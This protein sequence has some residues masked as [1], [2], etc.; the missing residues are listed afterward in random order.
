MRCGACPSAA[1]PSSGTPIRMLER[2]DRR[3]RSSTT[4]LDERVAPRVAADVVRPAARDRLVRGLGDVRLAVDRQLVDLR[5]GQ[6]EQ[7]GQQRDGGDHRDGD[8]ERRRRQPIAVIGREAGE[9]QA[10]DGDDDGGAGEQHGLTGGG[11]GGAGRVL[12]AHA[13][14][15]V[16]AVSGDDEQRVVDADAEADHHAEDQRDLGHV[17]ERRQDADAGDADEDAD[18]RGDDREAHRDHRAEGDEQH[19]DGDAEADQLAASIFLATSAIVPVSSTCTPA[20]RAGLEC[21]VDRVEVR[22]LDLVDEV[23]HV[24]ERGLAVGA[25]HGVRPT[26][27]RRRRRRRAAS[28]PSRRPRRC[29]PSSRR[30]SSVWSTMRPCTPPWPGT[31]LQDVGAGCDST[32]G[33]VNSVVRSRRRGR[34][35]SGEHGDGDEEPGTYDPP[36]VAGAPMTESVEER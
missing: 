3:W 27:R 10:E 5:A 15:E 2:R 23:R 17:R 36:G 28:G 34:R 11:V 20:S 35:C 6:A 16:L 4:R 22:G 24:D 1:L 26:R 21:G 30:P 19:D 31:G 18:Q 12:D 7:A 8:D 13:L 32:P 29:G 25:D 33:T 9:E 14:V